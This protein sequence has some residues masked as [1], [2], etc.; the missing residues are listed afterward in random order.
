MLRILPV[1][2]IELGLAAMRG[3]EHVG[4]AIDECRHAVAGEGGGQRQV[5]GLDIAL[6]LERRPALFGRLGGSGLV[7][8]LVH[9]AG[10]QTAF[11]VGGRIA[12]I[13]G[14]AGSFDGGLQ[15]LERLFPAGKAALAPFRWI[16]P[17]ELVG[18]PHQPVQIL[19][20]ADVGHAV[21]VRLQPL[22]HGGVSPSDLAPIRGG[23]TAARQHG[24][25]GA[26]GKA[27]EC[28]GDGW[29]AS[30]HGAALSKTNA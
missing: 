14:Q 13:N 28:G 10:L 6:A 22:A 3:D 12:I 25:G 8:R 1:D 16:A 29:K 4:G 24:N 20:H 18:Q 27:G 17:I 7:G 30:P 2:Q 5:H 19:A 15:R 21:H 11:G 23:G 9:G 26:G